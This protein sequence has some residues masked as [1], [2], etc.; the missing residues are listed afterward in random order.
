MERELTVISKTGRGGFE[1]TDFERTLIADAFSI[2]LEIPV[3]FR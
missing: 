2:Q 3:G 1:R